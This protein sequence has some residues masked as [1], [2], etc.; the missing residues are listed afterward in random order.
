MHAAHFIID[1]TIINTCVSES[2]CEKSPYFIGYNNGS[3]QL[4]RSTDSQY[5]FISTIDVLELPQWCEDNVEGYTIGDY[6][7]P[8]SKNCIACWPYLICDYY[9]NANQC[10]FC[11]MGDYRVRTRLSE[12]VAGKMIA[13]ALAF[14]YEYELALSGGTCTKPDGSLDYFTSVCKKAVEAGATYI[15]V[16]TTPPEDLDRINKLCEAG[17]TAIIMNLEIA[18]DTQRKAICPGKSLIPKQRYFDAFRRAVEVFGTGNVSSVLIAGLQPK[19]DIINMARDMT[20]MGVIP[21]IIPFKPLDGCLLN[22]MPPTNA[23]ELLEIAKAAE[24]FLRKNALFAS[25]QRGCTKCN[26]CSVE[27]LCENRS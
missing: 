19:R 12:D 22:T 13:K 10:K 20:E 11:S 2:F 14:S 4:I 27:A 25:E 5:E 16:E 1:D 3:L 17:A 26:G 24:G 23:I 7:R 15:S 21:T 18:D 8:H 9:S 6:I